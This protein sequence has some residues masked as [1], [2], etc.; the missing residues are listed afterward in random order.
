MVVDILGKMR[1]TGKPGSLGFGLCDYGLDPT[2]RQGEHLWWGRPDQEE[3]HHSGVGDNAGT[4]TTSD[5][6]VFSSKPALD[7]NY[8][9]AFETFTNGHTRLTAAIGRHHSPWRFDL[10]YSYKI[11]VAPCFR[12]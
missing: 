4:L 8:A 6:N 5:D 2:S 11:M 9:H 1:G 7:L 10:M 3:E 12:S